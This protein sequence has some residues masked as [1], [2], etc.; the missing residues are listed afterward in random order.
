MLV[1]GRVGAKKIGEEL[2][3]ITVT[4]SWLEEQLSPTRFEIKYPKMAVTKKLED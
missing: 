3:T 2:S 1:S 4:E